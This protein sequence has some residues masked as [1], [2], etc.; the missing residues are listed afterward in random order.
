M[1]WREGEVR[2]VYLLFALVTIHLV[3]LLGM[4]QAISALSRAASCGGQWEAAAGSPPAARE[5][6]L[7]P[8]VLTLN[9][10][11]GIKPDFAERPSRWQCRQANR[12]EGQLGNTELRRSKV[13][14]TEVVILFVFSRK[15]SSFRQ[16]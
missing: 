8:G 6:A 7:I 12:S 1:A 5:A 2:E 10:T 11:Q 4:F 13:Y 9:L 14:I 15:Y 16:G 3:R